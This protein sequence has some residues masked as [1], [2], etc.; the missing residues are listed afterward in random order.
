MEKSKKICYVVMGFGKKT[1]FETG[2]TLD[3]DKTYKNIIKPAVE[4]A[5][6]IC[7]RADEIVHAGVIDLP[8]YEQLL[9]ADIVIAD[10]STSN[11][12]A[13]YELGIRHAFRPFTTIVIAEDGMKWFPFDMN[14]VPVY[15]YHHLGEDI[16]YEEVMRFTNMLTNV[17][18]NRLNNLSTDSPVYTFLYNL[19]PPEIQDA[20]IKTMQKFIETNTAKINV[21]FETN[22]NTETKSI[23]QSLSKII[24]EGENALAKSDFKT[25]RESFAAARQL[26]KNDPYLIRQHALATYKSKLPDE[27]NA[28]LEAR[29][30]L[31]YFLPEEA[32]DTTDRKALELLGDIELALFNSTQKQYHLSRARSVYEKAYAIQAEWHNGITL[33]YLITLDAKRQ[34]IEEEKNIDAGLAKRTYRQ[35]TDLG[36]QRLA[37]ISELLK[38]KDRLSQSEREGYAKEQCQIWCAIAEAYYSMGDNENYYDARDKVMQNENSIEI[39]NALDKRIEVLSSLLAT[40]VN[41]HLQTQDGFTNEDFLKKDS[42]LVKEKDTQVKIASDRNVIFFSYSHEDTKWLIEIKKKLTPVF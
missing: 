14:H 6:L 35:V 18:I 23:N 1:D 19:R 11:K 39:L 26:D 8:M 32:T 20:D 28:L 13:L 10:L 37:A 40:G 33:A 3:L 21:S 24:E 5:G 36:K 12:N 16:P 7:V 31:K 34:K 2:R 41:S 29:K 30:I 42:G 17:I 4:A 9:N 15:P 27:N 22:F 38:F 25:A